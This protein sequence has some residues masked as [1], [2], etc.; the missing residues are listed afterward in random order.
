[1][2]ECFFKIATTGTLGLMNELFYMRRRYLTL[3]MR[4]AI[5][6]SLNHT[7]K[8]TLLLARLQYPLS[9]WIPLKT[10]KSCSVCLFLIS[11]FLLINPFSI[12][13]PS[14][15]TAL[16]QPE[17]AVLSPSLSAAGLQRGLKTK[18]NRTKWDLICFYFPVSCP[19]VFL[20]IRN[21]WDC[22]LENNIVSEQNIAM[23]SMGYLAEAKYRCPNPAREICIQQPAFSSKSRHYWT[24]WLKVLKQMRRLF[25]ALSCVKIMV[26][27]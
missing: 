23:E 11:G 4:A 7:E 2:R 14:V 5:H 18:R 3:G 26:C 9:S 16:L 12:S 24:E 17:N 15:S 22:A 8:F 25:R 10:F 21:Y 1:M 13:F 19:C 6:F 27:D 20:W